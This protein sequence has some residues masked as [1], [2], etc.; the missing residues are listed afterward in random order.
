ML[1]KND[2]IHLRALEPEDLELLYAWENK[3]TLWIH[4]NTLTPYSRLALRQ[5]ISDIQQQDIY[6]SKQL[7]LMIE[8]NDTNEVV[9]IVDLYDF[10]FH[11]S[12]VGIGILI[13]ESQRQKNY[14]T[15]T[16]ILI[17]EYVFQFLNIKQIYAYVAE[18][19]QSSLNLFR[20]SGYVQSAILKDWMCC[21]SEFKNM[22]VFQ[23]I[24]N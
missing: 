17:K 1:L 21:N 6:Q 13:D 7:R 8:T 19:N 14:A 16:L 9:G 18:N 15:Q 22:F 2:I 3:A 5:Y 11:N 24:N 4:G 23:L 10:D 20:K 12:K